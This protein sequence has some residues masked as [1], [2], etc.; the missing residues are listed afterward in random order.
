MKR[1][2]IGCGV[3]IVIFVLVLA[4]AAGAGRYRSAVRAGSWL[5]L[6]LH[7]DYLEYRPPSIL[8]T[9]L[10][11]GK[12]LLR[13]VTDALDKAAKDPKITGVI[14]RVGDLETGWARAGEIRDHVLAYR[15]SGKPA[16][17]YFETA[18]E[19]GAANLEYYLASAFE[20]IY[21]GPSGDI[22]LPGLMGE[23]LFLRG[24]LDLV[25]IYPDMEHIG[26]YKTAMNLFTEKAFT[27]AHREMLVAILESIQ[28]TLVTGIAEGRKMTREE[29]RAL[30]DRGLFLGA[31]ALEA[32]LVD[33]MKYRDEVLDSL[34]K[35][36][37][38]DLP[39]VKLDRY[40]KSVRRPGTTGK[41]TVG[42]VYGVGMV[43]RG[44]SEF[45]PAGS[46]M[47]M[48][49]DTVARTLRE[50]AEDKAVNAI[51]FRVDS[52]GGSYVASDIIWREVVR[53]REK[54]PVVVSMGDV[55]GS[56]GYFV[57]MPANEIVAQPGTITASI[58][59]L[60]GK[61]DMHGL[62][63]KLGITKEHVSL[64]PFADMYSDYQP[65]TPE[66]KAAQWKFL[67]RVYDD[68]SHKAA[69]GRNMKWEDVD[70]IGRGRVWTGQD[71]KR[72]GLVDHLGGM[73]VAIA[74]AKDLAKIPAGD[75][76]RLKFFPEEQTVWQALRS[77]DEEEAVV[78]VAFRGIRRVAA[79][80]W[81]LAAAAG[82]GT[83]E[84]VLMMPA[85]PEVR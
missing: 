61:L 41:K 81:R 38:K 66:Q 9:F 8:A 59:V 47:T 15:K 54:K 73:D 50:A 20:K 1:V 16:I 32:R 72:L 43:V 13:D 39:T 69:R 68:F 63:N 71:A 37:E 65:F 19:G 42:V 26:D 83:E 11:Q 40:L 34:K 24:T 45:D 10:L 49:S 55:A 23:G 6:D 12:P 84:R 48:G 31:E 5:E 25:G 22:G 56:G 58:G 64:T 44:K 33:G 51:V 67:R 18:G 85:L 77:R 7:G 74:R 62:Y 28:N 70:K 82:T 17:C 30:L 27:P 57:A 46:E 35:P 80:L 4:A 76:V 14:A 52:P 79:V 60:G 2:A 29:V 78:V 53:A 21:L 36:G 3:M 75:E